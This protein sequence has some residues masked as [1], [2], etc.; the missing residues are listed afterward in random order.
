MSDASVSEE[1]S[2]EH[3]MNLIREKWSQI[4]KLRFSEKGNGPLSWR[5]VDTMLNLVRSGHC[6]YNAG[7]DGFSVED[8]VAKESLV[9]LLVEPIPL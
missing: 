7:E 6:L 9:S 1:V 2:R 8:V 4:N 3:I 5:F